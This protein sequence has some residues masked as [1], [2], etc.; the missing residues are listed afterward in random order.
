[1]F[2]RKK[3][4]RELEQQ[5]LTDIF[6]LQKDWMHIKTIIEKSVEPSDEGLYELKVAQAKYFYLLGEARRLGIHAHQR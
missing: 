1:M 5:L 4:K 6:K 2:N 3:K